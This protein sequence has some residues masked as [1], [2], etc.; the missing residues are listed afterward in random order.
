MSMLKPSQLCLIRRNKFPKSPCKIVTFN[1]IKIL[2]HNL[3]AHK[4]PLAA[5]PSG[6]PQL[7][8]P[9]VFEHEDK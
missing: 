3:P 5:M 6:H 2:T 8:D 1:N 4:P 7:N 9:I